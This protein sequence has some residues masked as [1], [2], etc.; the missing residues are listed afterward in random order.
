MLVLEAAYLDR[1]A[2]LNHVQPSLLSFSA[3]SVVGFSGLNVT[4]DLCR[5]AGLTG[6]QVLVSLREAGDRRRSAR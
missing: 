4:A 2:R 3:L 6:P 1:I 5:R